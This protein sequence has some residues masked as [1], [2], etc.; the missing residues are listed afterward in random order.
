MKIT[1]ICAV[2]FS[3]MLIFTAC[4]TEESLE[5]TN[6]EAELKLLQPGAS[7]INLNFNLPDNPAMTIVWNDQLSSDSG[8]YTI[9]LDESPLFESPT[10]IGTSDS[11]RFT[12]S[13]SEFNNVVLGAGGDAFEPFTVFVRVSSGSVSSN[14]ISFSV[15]A[16][17][18]A[19]PIITNPTEGSSYVLDDA[20]AD[21]TILDLEWNDPDF[22]DNSSVDVS[23][24]V[25]FAEAGTDFQTISSET[26]DDGTS[27]ELT[28]AELNNIALVS[29]IDAETN[30]TLDLRIIATIMMTGGNMTRTSESVSINVTPY[31]AGATPASWGIIGSGYNNWG[32][33][34]DG[35]LYT[36]DDPN[37]FVTYLT[38]VDGEI[39]FREN[40]DWSSNLGDNDADGTVEP[41]GANIAVTAGTYKITLD[42]NNNT[43]SLEP[44]SLGIV[45]SG[46][47]AW[48]DGGPD[49]KFYYD[50]TT[51]TFKVG[52]RLLDGEIKFRTN[53]AWDTNY[54]GTGGN[55]AQEG[56]NIV[57]TEGHY[58]VTVDLNNNSYSIV[59]SDVLGIVGSGYNNWG[60]TPDF[61]LTEIQPDVYV[62]DIV[63]LVDGEIKFR[64]NNAWDTD[65]GDDGLDGTL[66]Q[67]GADIPVQAGLYRVELDLSTNQYALNK[68]Q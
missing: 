4:E 48:G 68:V 38:L 62:G 21:D 13:V 3:V 43:Y 56:A 14:N 20:T 45:G 17:S 51:D 40:N 8:N 16:Y 18:E 66:E 59:E 25:Q 32:A 63:T 65:Y 64:V 19:A 53:N 41:D 27:L 39:K 6:P 49:A 57:S 55:L 11:E 5:I 36:T 37:V 35:T 10:I 60:E 9:E 7:N 1:K 58:L 52:V 26:I 2:I 61:S 28:H 31:N 44:F 12:L 42:L 15:S 54:G 34:E 67:G 22:G 30:G 29:G 33:F 24:E 46:Y 23:Y 50:Y 47:N